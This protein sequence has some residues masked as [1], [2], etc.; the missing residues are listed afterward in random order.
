MHKEVVCSLPHGS[1]PAQCIM[2]LELE[3]SRYAT[4]ILKRREQ[5]YVRVFALL[6]EGCSYPSNIQSPNKTV[7]CTLYTSTVYK[8]CNTQTASS[9]LQFLKQ[10]PLF[11]HSAPPN[12]G[13]QASGK[14]NCCHIPFTF[15]KV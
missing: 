7:L 6:G 4:Q 1:Q 10:R 15:N 11:C 3:R 12:K 8:L 13:R 2:H 14:N 9:D 5:S